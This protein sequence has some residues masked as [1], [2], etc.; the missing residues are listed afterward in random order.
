MDHIKIIFFDIDGTLI[1]MERKQ[2]TPRML[3]TLARLQANG[4]KL[5]IATGRAPMVVPKFEGVEF[6]AFLT[7]NGSYCYDREGVLFSNPL[8]TADVHA[9]IR[10]ASA[11]GRP[12]ALATSTRLAANGA[13]Q[14]L[15]DYFAIA[16]EPLTIADDFDQLAEGEVFQL[17]MGCRKADYP[18]ILQDVANAKIAGWWDR[19]VDVIPANGG[20]GIGVRKILETYGFDKSEAMAFGDGNN[21]IEMLEAVG[22]G[23]A[24]ANASADLKAIAEDVC[25]SV[26]EDGIYYY[27][28]EKGLI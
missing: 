17:L 14:D 16:K 26:T 15:L 13:D 20:K 9:L 1:D 2:I 22:H 10:N 6:D 11:L 21:D 12:V 25:G 18:R 8:P 7:Y 4:I 5:C 24:M 28:K 3:E 23:I 27:C 19:A